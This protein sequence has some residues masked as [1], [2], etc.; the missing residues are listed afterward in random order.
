MD[1]DL[2]SPVSHLFTLR[3]WQ[4]VLGD[5]RNEWRGQVRYVLTGETYYFRQWDQLQ[6]TLRRCLPGFDMEPGSKSHG[7]RPDHVALGLLA[8]DEEGA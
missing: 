1:D 6:E 5:G 2:S 7:G 8:S 3:I 4:E